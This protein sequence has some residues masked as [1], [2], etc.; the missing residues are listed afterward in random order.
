MKDNKNII[1][2]YDLFI[3][4]WDG[5][6]S[7]STRLI[8]FTKIFRKRYRMH[9]HAA[10]GE[11]P[12]SSMKPVSMKVSKMNIYELEERDRV[13]SWLYSIY[14]LIEKPKMREG[15]AE[16]IR[17]L[18]KRGKKV[19]VLSDSRARR[20]M[21]EI[22][23]QNLQESI[24]MI[25]SSDMINVYKP[26]P[27]GIHFIMKQLKEKKGTTIYIGD[28]PSD[29]I[30]ARFAGVAACAVGG[31]FESDRALMEA[32]PEHFFSSILEMYKKLKHL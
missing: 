4:D 21:Q 18:K 29:V 32:N 6:L 22:N 26:D 9:R 20:L 23:E 16:L 15:A 25:I 5:T 3:F 17:L 12:Y 19:A 8:K 10:L 31:G 27:R 24:D 13:F 2:N 7:T 11:N 28:M 14:Y 30:T 1:N